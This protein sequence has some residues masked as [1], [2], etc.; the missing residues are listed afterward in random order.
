MACI[1]SSLAGA[2]FGSP[3]AKKRSVMA[4]SQLS[5]FSNQVYV[6]FFDLG[7]RY[8]LFLCLIRSVL[9]GVEPALLLG[10]AGVLPKCFYSVLTILLLLFHILL[11]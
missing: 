9:A 6:Y 5:S 3:A 4:T 1:V 2:S 7:W 11:T 8:V 10:K